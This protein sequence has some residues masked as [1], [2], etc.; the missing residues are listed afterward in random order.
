MWL[1]LSYMIKSCVL[2]SN[3]YSQIP[4]NVIKYCMESFYSL[5][6]ALFGVRNCTYNTHVMSCHL[7]EMRCNGPLTLTSAFPFES[8][9]GELR[10]SFVPGTCS[11]LKQ[12]LS[13]VMMKRAICPHKCEKTFFTLKKIRLWNVTA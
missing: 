6:Q 13:N 1:Y 4:P 11:T 5:Y 2:P 12:M 7:L 10:Q 9:Y 3:E 8:F